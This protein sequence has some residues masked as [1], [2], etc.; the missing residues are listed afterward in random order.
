MTGLTQWNLALK[1]TKRAKAI[2]EATTHIEDADII[3]RVSRD[4][5]EAMV[6]IYISD[7]PDSE[8]MQERGW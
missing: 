7:I 5:G 3:A 6:G 1:R 4:L 2:V 8:R